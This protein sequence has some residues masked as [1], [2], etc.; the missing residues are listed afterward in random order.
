MTTLHA[1]PS[2]D[3][4]QFVSDDDPPAPLPVFVTRATLPALL[5][6]LST[7]CESGQDEAS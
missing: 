4:V 1:H 2:A 6:P 3:T 5:H 7:Q